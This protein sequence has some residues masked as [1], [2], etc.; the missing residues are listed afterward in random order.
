VTTVVMPRLS[1][2]MEQGTV[3]RWLKADGDRVEVGEELVEI[4]TDKATMPYEAETAGVLRRLAREGETVDLGAPLAELLPE[5]NGRRNGEARIAASPVA[6]RLAARV[7]VDLTTLSGSGP[8]GRVVKRDVEAAAAPRDAAPPAAT[9]PLSTPAK[10]AVATD[11]LSRVQH[12]VARRMAE[13]RATVPDFAI[14]MHVDADALVALR[15]QLE[16]DLPDEAPPSFNDFVVKACARA[17][18]LHPRVNGAYRDAT[19]ERYG[20]VNVGVAVAAGDALVVPVVADAD[21][22]AIG[23]VARET[24][25]LAER[26]RAGE[27][28]PPELAGGTFTVSNLGMFGVTR[29]E[30]V[31]NAPQAAILAVGALERRPVVRGDELRAGHAMTLTLCSDHRVLYGADAAAFLADIRAGLEQP[32]RLLV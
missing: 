7:G 31:V 13:S 8:R 5:S 16:R 3:V 4:E 22:K 28:T 2:A 20:R 17:L 32:L 18:R 1:D 23:A 25:R 14:D 6:R 27:L 30:A 12:T 11:P 9:S 19:V 24:R 29:F 15:A 26:A 10:G 21:V